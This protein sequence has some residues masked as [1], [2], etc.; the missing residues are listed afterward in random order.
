MQHVTNNSKFT[1]GGARHY[2]KPESSSMYD[3]NGKV[4]QL[5][6]VTELSRT[7]EGKIYNWFW[8]EPV[9]IPENQRM[10]QNNYVQM[11]LL[12]LCDSSTKTATNQ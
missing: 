7:Q 3:A 9:H 5:W 10:F 8:L 12:F 4:M 6:F 11:F 2:T 1:I